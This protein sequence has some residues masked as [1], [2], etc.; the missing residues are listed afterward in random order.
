MK[1]IKDTEITQATRQCYFKSIENTGFKN[2]T[3]DYIEVIE[4][5]N[6]LGFDVDINSYENKR[7]QL[8]W[9]E[10][11]ELKNIIKQIF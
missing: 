5:H 2:S 3:D 10:W 7:F 4:W 8:T 6:G 9:E 11:D 1:N